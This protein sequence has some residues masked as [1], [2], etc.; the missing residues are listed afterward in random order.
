MADE[1]ARR[2]NIIVFMSDDVGWGDLGC[3]GGG[4]NRGAPDAEPR[5]AGGRGTAV[6]VVLRPA[7]LHARAGPRR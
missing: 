7:E 4:E 6:P 3:Y 5:S 2:P 1:S